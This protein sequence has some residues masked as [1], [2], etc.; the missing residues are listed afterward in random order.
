MAES[1]AVTD[2]QTRSAQLLSQQATVCKQCMEF[3]RR[4]SAWNSVFTR[5]YYLAGVL[6]TE[7]PTWSRVRP[8]RRQNSAVGI[9]TGYGLDGRRVGVRVPV[10][11]GILF[12]TSSRPALE[13][14][15][16]LI[17]RVPGALSP[18]VKRPGREADHSPPA[19]AEVKKTWIYTSIPAHS[20]PFYSGLFASL[21][22][23]N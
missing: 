21:H 20:L 9:A 14:T 23:P 11:S 16:P 13:P 3:R 22:T 4:T 5:R 18:A 1:K 10:R 15:L 8:E 6:C 2:V 7:A 17:Q 19:S 12:S